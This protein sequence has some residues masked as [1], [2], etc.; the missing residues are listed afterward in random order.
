[1]LLTDP[2]WS[3]VCTAPRCRRIPRQALLIGT[4]P[5]QKPGNTQSAAPQ[6]GRLIAFNHEPD[7]PLFGF[8]IVGLY[9]RAAGKWHPCMGSTRD[10]LWLWC[11]PCTTIDPQTWLG[12]TPYDESRHTPCRQGFHSVGLVVVRRTVDRGDL[13]IYL[14]RTGDFKRKPPSVDAAMINPGSPRSFRGPKGTGI[15]GANHT[16]R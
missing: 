10:H 1:M 14:F 3:E 6:S 5:L 7:N 4:L 15:S 2:A 12:A 16:V 8:V 11:H 9:G 13:L